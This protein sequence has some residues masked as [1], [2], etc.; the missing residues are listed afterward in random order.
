M[1]YDEQKLYYTFTPIVRTSIWKLN[2][3]DKQK[4]YKQSLQNFY[5]SENI[6]PDFVWAPFQNT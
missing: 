1:I 5:F 4:I 6:A 3:M 2:G